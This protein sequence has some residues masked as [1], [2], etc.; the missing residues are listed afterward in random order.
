MAKVN[1]SSL[2]DD[3]ALVEMNDPDRYNALTTGMVDELKAA[4]ADL[5]TD[6]SV[7]AVVLTGQGRGFCAGANMTGD[8][9]QP[10]P[11]ARPRPRRH[12]PLRPGEPRGAD[13]GHP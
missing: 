9:A 7:R 8:D 12:H 10:D 1:R 2:R 4:F 13:P 3:V 11:G 6:R 5:R